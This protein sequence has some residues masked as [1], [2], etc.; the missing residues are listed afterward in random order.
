MVYKVFVY[1]VEYITH[2]KIDHEPVIV[3]HTLVT[4]Y[5]YFKDS[6]HKWL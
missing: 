5:K 1:D 6:N 4:R 2:H 3:Y